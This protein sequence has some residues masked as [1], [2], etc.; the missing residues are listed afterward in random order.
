MWDLIKHLWNDEIG[1]SQSTEMA[2]VTGVTIGSLVM[3]MRSFGGAVNNR[4]AEVEIRDDSLAQLQQKIAQE[5]REK[6]LTEEQRIEQIRER[7]RVQIERR[8]QQA[9]TLA[10]HEAPE[11]SDD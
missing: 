5:R 3:G 2:L 11:S 7:R 10:S 1:S 9:E 6:E 8:K 4:F